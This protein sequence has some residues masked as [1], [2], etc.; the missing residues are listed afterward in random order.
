VNDNTLCA[1]DVPA[2]GT[3]FAVRGAMSHL[4]DVD[5][6]E[7]FRPTLSI[8][9]AF[10][11]GTFLFLAILML[12]RIIPK[13][14]IGRLALADLIVVTLVAGVA[15]NGLVRDAYS[16][17]D[18]LLV[19]A[20][21]IGWS[22]V[23]DWGSY[24]SRL[25]HV[26]LHQP[27]V[28][29][30]KDGKVDEK[31][32]QGEMVTHDQLCCQ[33]RAL[34]INSPADVAEG[35]MESNGRVSAVLRAK[36]NA[37]WLNG[38]N[39]RTGIPSEIAPRAKQ[40]LL[41]I[42]VINDLDFEEGAQLLRFALPMA[43]RLHELAAR[44]RAAGAPVIYVNDNFGHWRSDFG[45]TVEHC[46]SDE[47][48]GRPI[49]ERLLPEDS[50][51]FVLKPRHSGFY[52]T[53]LETLLRHLGVDTLIVTGIAGNICVH[54]TA[55]DAYL[56]GYHVVAP[57]DGVASNTQEDTDNALA[58]MQKVLKAET[59]LS[60]DIVFSSDDEVANTHETASRSPAQNGSTR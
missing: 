44:A 25:I 11:R 15:R 14:L 57:R 30:I 35:W 46:L 49:V 16:L 56:R 32:L 41:L 8:P 7:L 6:S 20:T 36:P 4:F 1:N 31:N 13:R 33:L 34:G 52:S 59:P 47:S 3:R 22:Y 39:G 58:Q 53:T 21:I 10:L 51:Y 40:A 18:C 26:L 54:F 12:F 2:A 24:R 60:T 17:T 50:D 48:R 45:A 23:L 9:E 5:W 38:A 29:L 28:R 42:D 19:I 37:R 55:Y 27:A 43:D